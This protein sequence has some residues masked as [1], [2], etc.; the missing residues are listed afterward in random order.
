MSTIDS[1]SIRP[2]DVDL[3][4]IVLLQSL[5]FLLQPPKLAP[6]EPP[7]PA[8]RGRL[9]CLAGLT[10]P[11]YSHLWPVYPSTHPHLLL[12]I[13]DGSRTTQ[14]SYSPPRG[15]PLPYLPQLHAVPFVG[16][17][18]VHR[19]G[20][21]GVAWS[22]WSTNNIHRKRTVRGEA[23][24]WIQGRTQGNASLLRAK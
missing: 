10:A 15:Q 6:A 3:T 12:F 7:A 22:M 5:I 13:G 20:A 9:C 18:I 1:T 11:S 16:I 17:A 24:S 8:S 19:P 21:L 2:L 14:P 23:D 4:A